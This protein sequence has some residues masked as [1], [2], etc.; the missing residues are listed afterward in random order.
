MERE[1]VF[2]RTT[3]SENSIPKNM[4]KIYTT[5]NQ[6]KEDLKKHNKIVK[7][8]NKEQQKALKYYN[9]KEELA[10]RNSS[11]KVNISPN[12]MKCLEGLNLMIGANA[13]YEVKEKTDKIKNIKIKK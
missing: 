8:L 13:W 10:K 3:K 6:I 2:K 9:D 7:T 4:F 12:K 11:V 5:D 1:N